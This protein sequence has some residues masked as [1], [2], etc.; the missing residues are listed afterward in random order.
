MGWGDIFHSTV[1]IFFINEK[2]YFVEGKERVSF[3][4]RRHKKMTTHMDSLPR[5]YL[6]EEVFYYTEALVLFSNAN[7]NIFFSCINNVCVR[8]FVSVCVRACVI[9]CAGWTV[10]VPLGFCSASPYII[11]PPI[12]DPPLFHDLTHHPKRYQREHRNSTK[13]AGCDDECTETH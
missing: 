5:F 6:T 7:V 13:L 2:S 8:M 3:A 1:G 10:W 11:S 12:P 4:Y 9:V